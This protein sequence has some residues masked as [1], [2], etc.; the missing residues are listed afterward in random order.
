MYQI[1][2]K[3]DLSFVLTTGSNKFQFIAKN[4]HELLHGLLETFG[5]ALFVSP[6][7]F[8]DFSSFFSNVSR[9]DVEIELITTCAPKGRDQLKKPG[10]IT[11]FAKSI[12]K[13]TGQWPLIGLDQNLHSK[14][15][16][17]YDD[18][19][20][21]VG[22]VT[23]ANLTYSGLSKNTETGIVITN[24]QLLH[25][26]AEQARRSLDFVN[27]S[28][29]QLSRLRMAVEV[30]EKE[31]SEKVSED[32]DI[33]LGNMLEGY[34]T[35]SAGNRGVRLREGAEYY[36]KVSGVRDRPILPEDAR[37]FDEP[38]TD[39]MFAKSP[40]NIKLGDCLLEVAVGGMCFLSYYSCASATYE[41]TDEEKKD[42][43]DY[44]R[45]P[46]YIYANNLSLHYG[47]CWFK[48]PLYYGDVIQRFKQ[49]YP[50]I[51]VTVAGKDHILG[52]IQMGHSYIHVTRQFGEFVKDEIDSHKC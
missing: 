27:V 26:I 11:S 35:P 46:F 17:Y 43:K 25:E 10:S 15:Y 32:I 31:Y 19:T 6:F 40:N 30:M 34:C 49:E 51:S 21:V 13:I 7:L 41:R 47:G 29:Y 52:A 2:N 14:I 23:S 50:D 22:V 12:E 42:D 9:T 39:L 16:V 38:H 3:S 48:S 28:D 36:I 18:S 1:T 4:H 5:K 8:D 33:G 20:P 44:Q 24:T 45:W 37:S